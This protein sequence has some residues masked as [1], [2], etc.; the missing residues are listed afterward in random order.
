M[1][2]PLLSSTIS[3]AGRVKNDQKRVVHCYNRVEWMDKRAD[4]KKKKRLF[5]RQNLF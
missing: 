2:I 1:E 4:E 5:S 3:I